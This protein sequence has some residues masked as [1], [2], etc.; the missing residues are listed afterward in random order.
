MM[1]RAGPAKKLIIYISQDDRY[2]S[3]PLYEALLHFF[4]QRGCA[5]A[6]A[7]KGIA[8]F[9]AHGVFHTS[10]LLRLT[11]NLPI[12]IEV[13]ESAEKINALLPFVYDMVTEGLIELQDTEVIKYSHKHEVKEE[14]NLHGVKLEGRAMML[15]IY[16]DENDRFE[17]APLYEAIVKRLKMVDMAGATVFKGIMGYG[18]KSRVHR[19]HL[20]GIGDDLPV[21][22]TVVDTEER[23]RQVLPSLD[24]MVK[25]GLVVLS[26]V[27]IIKYSHVH[28]EDDKTIL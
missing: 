16:V 28:D 5:G 4:H 20:L 8:G 9:G 19:K 23:I 15:R 3:L 2:E 7:T 21:L 24:D 12:R 14:Q 22:I 26:D 6:T 11:Q 1:L 10:K 18:A 17:G 13:V 27:E 25:E